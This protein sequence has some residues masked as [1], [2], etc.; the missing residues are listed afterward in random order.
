MNKSVKNQ[1]S[2]LV[3]DLCRLANFC[4][5]YARETLPTAAVALNFSTWSDI[6]NAIAHDKFCD[7]VSGF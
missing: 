4:I 2:N 6:I 7:I 3:W 1:F 5:N